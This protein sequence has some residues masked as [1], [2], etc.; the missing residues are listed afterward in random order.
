MVIFMPSEMI[1]L[2]IFLVGV[3]RANAVCRASYPEDDAG[4]L[5]DEI[6]L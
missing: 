1:K 5:N 3:W 2:H 6:T 4:Q